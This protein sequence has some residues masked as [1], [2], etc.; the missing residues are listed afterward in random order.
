MLEPETMIT[1]IL[2]SMLLGLVPGPDNIFV[3]TQSAL[4]GSKAGIVVVLGLCTGLIVHTLAVS[5]G[6]AAIFQVSV[7]AFTLLKMLGAL[8]LLYLAW[9][10]FT[11]INPEIQNRNS[12]S[13]KI[14][15]LYGRGLI[16]NI[17]N[18]KVSIFFLAFLPQFIDPNRGSVSIQIY[19]LGGIFIL[20]TLF[21]F[22]SIAVLSGLISR[23]FKR[24]SVA[25]QMMNKVA[26]I[27]YLGLSVKIAI[28]QI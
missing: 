4:H 25:Q 26:G 3:L 20:V 22:G 8:Y 6:I 15:K 23:L 12:V 14:A 21:V 11:A 16:M 9:G 28:M 10:A 27:I 13:P 17:T 2:A 19:E 1:F 24:S 18:P 7:V 5:M